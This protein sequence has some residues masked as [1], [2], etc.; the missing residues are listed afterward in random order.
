MSS[1]ARIEVYSLPLCV[2][3]IWP[4]VPIS[5]PKPHWNTRN[6]KIYRWISDPVVFVFEDISLEFPQHW[7]PRR[8]D[9]LRPIS[10][11]RLLADSLSRSSGDHPSQLVVTWPVI[12]KLRKFLRNLVEK[13]AAFFKTSFYNKVTLPL[14]FFRLHLPSSRILPS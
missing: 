9:K 5:T 1:L 3:H 4:C 8:K 11:S 7:K 2:N 10:T 13:L 14:D 12:N 6:Q